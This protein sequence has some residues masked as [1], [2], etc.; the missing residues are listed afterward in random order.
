[1][2]DI[3]PVSITPAWP[4]E[5]R[6]HAL[7]P[8]FDTIPDPM[9]TLL[10]WLLWKYELIN[11]TWEKPPYSALTGRRCNHTTPE[12]WCSF[13]VAQQAYEKSQGT[14]NPYSGVGFELDDGLAGI[15]LDSCLSDSGCIQPDALAIVKATA[16]WTEV[17]ASGFG[18]HVYVLADLDGGARHDCI[19][20]YGTRRY[21]AV[22]G[23][24]YHKMPLP[25]ARRQAF[26]DELYLQV[27]ESQK[28]SIVPNSFQVTKAKSNNIVTGGTEQPRKRWKNDDELIKAACDSRDTAFKRLWHGDTSAYGN[29]HSRADFALYGKLWYWTDYDRGRTE[30]LFEQS[31][32][33]RAKFNRQGYRDYMYQK[34]PGVR[35]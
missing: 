19:E 26:V 33:M 30:A 20:I 4:T 28:K 3:I 12:S 11:N 35:S 17:S 29:D 2:F 16:S 21:F 34:M 6:P 23:Q 31:R 27:S 8:C 1:M 7:A 14:K 10:R 25:I 24:S 32:L 18:T 5:A 15:D 13:D 9:K 22:T